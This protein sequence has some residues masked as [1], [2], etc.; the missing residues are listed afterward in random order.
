M[1][2]ALLL[3]TASAS[4]AAAAAGPVDRPFPGGGISQLA[5]DDGP[6]HGSFSNV[7][8]QFDQ[9]GTRPGET[10]CTWRI[11]VGLA[12]EGFELCPTAFEAGKTIWTSGEQFANG[13]VASGAKA[14]GLRGTPGQVLCVV[15]SQTSSDPQGVAGSST[16]LKAILMDQD[17][18]TPVEAVELKILRASPPAQIQPPP[19][20]IPFYVSSNCRS[21][22]IGATQY[23][24]SYRL[25]GCR[26]ATNLAAAA[27]RSATAPNGYRCTTKAS[28]GK[29]C[30]RQGRSKRYLEWHLPKASGQTAAVRLR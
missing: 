18:V 4:I 3:L 22:T 19:T 16:V 9:C 14:F 15:L 7:A 24:F 2:V 10:A 23:S 20:A 8:F 17:L 27:Y 25:M 26:K 29:R 28:G 1:A 6:S 12:P 11:D 5:I 21:L 13:A 30:W